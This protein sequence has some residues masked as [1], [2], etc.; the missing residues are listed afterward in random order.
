MSNNEDVFM[1]DAP[2]MVNALS[3][4]PNIRVREP[5]V[6][7]GER[8]VIAIQGWL[9]SLELYYKLTKM[10]DAQTQLYYA[11]SLLR[12]DA[13]LWFNQLP[14]VREGVISFQTFAAF[15]E[16]LLAEF[17]PVHAVLSARDDL[18]ELSQTGTV[19]DYINSFRRLRLQI[20]DLSDGDAL[21]RFVHGLQDHIRSEVRSRFPVNLPAAEAC[22][23]ALEAAGH[24]SS[25]VPR[26]IVQQPAV[27]IPPPAN[28]PMDLD[29][30]RSFLNALNGQR[31]NNGNFRPNNRSQGN[32]GASSGP[33]CYGCGGFGHLKR[34][35][36][37]VKRRKNQGSSRINGN[38]GHLNA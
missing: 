16:A 10:E 7:N 2:P 4:T 29:V 20:P 25:S 24:V 30:L 1:G 28:D 9:N 8:T 3:G 35:C 22:A 13:Q 12:E 36:P 38:N 21:D 27:S 11:L 23:L 18:W 37:T 17:V 34:E 6:Y 31:M 14:G 15:K 33:R 5:E 32:T 19:R 26:P